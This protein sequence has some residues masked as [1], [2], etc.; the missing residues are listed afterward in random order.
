MLKLFQTPQY[1]KLMTEHIHHTIRYL[2]DQNQEFALACETKYISFHPELPSEIKKTFRETVLFIISGYT[3][4]SSQ[5]T[6][7]CFSFE[8]GFG[9]ENFGSTVQIPLLAIRQIFVEDH[10]V[11]INLSEPAPK[12]EKK[13]KT[14]PSETLSMAALLKNPENQKLLKKKEK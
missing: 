1:R 3:Y 6:D 13:D 12:D 7:D 11:V 5:L 8:A 14:A 2:F 9:S 4:E 10:P